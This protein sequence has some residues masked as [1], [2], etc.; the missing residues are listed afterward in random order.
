MSATI[1]AH[2]FVAIGHLLIIAPFLLYVGFQRANTPFWIYTLLIAVGAMILFYHG[3]K[4]FI[5]VAT[6]SPYAWVN[7]IH[8]AFIA[9]LLLFIGFKGRDAPRYAYELLI[10]VGFA[11][12]GYHLY[13]LI[14]GLQVYYMDKSKKIGGGDYSH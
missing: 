3:Y 2:V 10:M 7:I 11:A 1:D 4:S 13:S 6:G 14:R 8:V 9:P 12:L 5:R